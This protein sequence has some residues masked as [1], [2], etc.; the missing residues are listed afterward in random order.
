M[1]EGSVVLLLCVQAMEGQ[2]R[3][4]PHALDVDYQEV[5]LQRVLGPCVLR[6]ETHVYQGH[7]AATPP[8]HWLRL[9]PGRPRQPG[10]GPGRRI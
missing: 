3:F 4:P 5:G 10:P 8:G 6:L 9:D 7:E 2:D 1:S